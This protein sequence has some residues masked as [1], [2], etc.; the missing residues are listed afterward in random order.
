MNRAAQLIA[1]PCPT[2]PSPRAHLKVGERLVR[3]A[4]TCKGNTVVATEDR[5]ARVDGEATVEVVRGL[6]P[7]FLLL[8]HQAQPKPRVIVAR[9]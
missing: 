7:L 3:L 9:L 6:V 4:G 5:G 8:V 1:H 2:S